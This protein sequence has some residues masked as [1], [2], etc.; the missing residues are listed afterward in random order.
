MLH[1]EEVM[2]S[3]VR[4]QETMENEKCKRRDCKGIKVNWRQ[5]KKNGHGLVL[6]SF[7]TEKSETNGNVSE[8]EKAK[9]LFEIQKDTE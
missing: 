1:W 6:M 2:H 8:E 5:G 3:M 7:Y 4:G 9:K